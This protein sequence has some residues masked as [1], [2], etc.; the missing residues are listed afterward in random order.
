MTSKS[1]SIFGR[2]AFAWMI[3]FGCA[4]APVAAEVEVLV[5]GT[6]HLANPGQDVHNVEVDDI[7]SARRQG[8]LQAV[9][10]ALAA[11]VPDKVAV[12]RVS[13]RDDLSL[14]AFESFGPAVLQDEHSESAQIG[15]RLADKL[16][17]DKVYGIDE[18]DESIN[19][20]P[21]GRITEYAE[22]KGESARDRLDDINAQAKR[23]ARAV[24][25]LHAESTI[26]RTLAWINQPETIQRTF[27]HWYYGMLEL[28]DAKRQ[29]GA[30]LNGRYYLRN[31]RIFTK[32]ASIAQSGDR[33]VVVFGSG[34]AYWLRHF[35]GETPGFSLV[36]ASPYLELAG[37]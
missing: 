15:Y 10:D 25:R 18:Q 14:E 22:G 3:L 21:Y 6:Y 23:Y 20:F 26:G 37:N 8:Q 34:H 27:A 11:F 13:E 19:Y 5:L 32:L 17:L 29:P 16:E 30:L 33:V 2:T 35:V 24:G 9:A 4:T 12:E 1:A 7:T 36:E 31:A 28:A